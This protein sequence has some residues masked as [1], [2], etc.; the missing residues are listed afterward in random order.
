MVV[1]HQ[2]FHCINTHNMSVSRVVT[3]EEME[4]MLLTVLCLGLLQLWE[5]VQ[6]LQR[7]ELSPFSMC[8]FCCCNPLS[9]HYCKEHPAE[10]CR[11]VLQ[12]LW[13][14]SLLLCGFMKLLNLMS[15]L[16]HR[17]AKILTLSCQSNPGWITSLAQVNSSCLS[18]CHRVASER[19]WQNALQACFKKH[20]VW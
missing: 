15:S 5:S 20:L 17:C 14:S 10:K 9:N 8:W 4:D 7:P 1:F 19:C 18:N 2:G 11:A 13:V 3:V 16:S 12:S 6:K